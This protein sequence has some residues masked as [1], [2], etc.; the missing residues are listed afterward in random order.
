MKP[1]VLMLRALLPRQAAQ[2]DER[3]TAHRL[4]LAKDKDALLKQ[5]A[6]EVVAIVTSGELGCNAS[7]MDRLPKLGLVAC[8]GVGVDGIDL[9]Y[10]RK[11]GIPVSNTPDVLT[12]DVADLAM[13][14]TIS[15][16]RNIAGADRFVR[17]GGW[18]NGPLP[19]AIRLT[20]KTMGIIGLGRIGKAIGKRA[21]AHG[22][23]IVWHGR[24]EQPDVGWQ[25]HPELE[26]MAAE[27][28]VMMVACPGG[29]ATRGLVSRKV[30]G[31]LKPQSY[32]VNISR[33]SVVDEAALVEALREGRIA[34]AALD[35]F[36]DEP[37]VPEPL[38]KM[39]NVVLTSHIGSATRETRDAMAQLVVDNLD[40]FASGRPLITP[41]WFA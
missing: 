18:Q 34:G 13:G 33:G 16:M 24:S 37:N 3:Y 12:D 36:V 5:V 7:L 40:A 11:R 14:L 23:A 10:C 1:E 31:R 38:T 22:M 20:G 8:F 4:D 19:L 26:D 32:L 17:H 41:W 6:P 39:E 21:I 28:D 35:V 29:Q 25:R 30:L 27:V 9:A 2:I 15:L